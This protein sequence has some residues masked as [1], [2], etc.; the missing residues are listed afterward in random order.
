MPTPIRQLRMSDDLWFQL[1]ATGAASVYIRSI[2]ELA[3]ASGW[4]VTANGVIFDAN[5]K[6]LWPNSATRQRSL[7]L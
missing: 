4:T 6:Q 1:R 2:L 3:L 7:N 5:G